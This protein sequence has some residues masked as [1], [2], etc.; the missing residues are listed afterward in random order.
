MHIIG[1]LPKQKGVSLRQPL[2]ILHYS[3]TITTPTTS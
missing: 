1:T 3:L 2:P